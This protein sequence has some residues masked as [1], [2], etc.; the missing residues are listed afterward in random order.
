M[1]PVIGGLIPLA[2]I[3]TVYASFPVVARIGARRR[4]IRSLICVVDLR[5]YR[6]A[7]DRIPKLVAIGELT[8]AYT[9]LTAMDVWLNSQAKHGR[10]S[11]RDWY[12]R[13]I[14]RW[15]LYRAEVV[16]QMGGNGLAVL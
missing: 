2:A 16:D 13:E 14:D 9:G 8:R 6:E 1:N 7:A 3:G 10:A 5:T 11:R 12:N 15:T 4:D